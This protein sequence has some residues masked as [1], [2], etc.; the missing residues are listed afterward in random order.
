METAKLFKNGRSQA[1][2]LPVKYRFEGDEVYI[3]KT[4]DGVL[5]MPIS[6]SIWDKWEDNLSNF[7]ESFMTERNQPKYQE[8]EGLDEI[9]T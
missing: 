8:R 3:K 2:R 1:V 6:Q 4:R 5:L 9:F 7:D